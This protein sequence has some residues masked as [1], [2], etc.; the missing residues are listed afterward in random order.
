MWRHWPRLMVMGNLLEGLRG[1]EWGGHCKWETFPS[2]LHGDCPFQS[3]PWA[4]KWTDAYSPPRQAR[5]HCQKCP[6]SF[7]WFWS[8][9]PQTQIEGVCSRHSGA[10][11]PW[12]LPLKT[13]YLLLTKARMQLGSRRSHPSCPEHR[14]IAALATSLDHLGGCRNA[15]PAWSHWHNGGTTLQESRLQLLQTAPH[16]SAWQGRYV[17][18]SCRTLALVHCLKKHSTCT[19]CNSSWDGSRACPPLHPE[20]AAV[21]PPLALGWL[22]SLGSAQSCPTLEWWNLQNLSRCSSWSVSSSH[23][24]WK[25]PAGLGLLG[26][27]TPVLHWW[28]DTSTTA[29]WARMG[30]H[31]GMPALPR[32]DRTGAQA[33]SASGKGPTFCLPYPKWISWLPSIAGLLPGPCSDK[34]S[35]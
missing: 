13:C 27:W 25:R 22:C 29:C 3:V 31:G 23:W 21:L 2:W 26:R 4:H 35:C 6:H 17:T 18:K 34:A 33:G 32:S 14:T 19:A 30:T 20:P 9:G 1:A 10:G 15:W 8:R 7:H 28:E 5:C 24:W 16:L 11:W 12:S